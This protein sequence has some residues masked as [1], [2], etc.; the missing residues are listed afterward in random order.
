MNYKSTDNLKCD[1]LIIGAGVIGLTTAYE[2]KKTQ[3][4]CTIAI[5]EKEPDVARHASGRNS[6]VLHAGFYY[7]SDSLKA[8]FTKDGNRL[9]KEFC[10]ENEIYINECKKVVVATNEEELKSLYE[11]EKRG[12]QNNVDVR[13][14]D[15]E[16]LYQI[17]PNS[18][19]FKKALFSPTT[20]S[21]NPVE[22]CQKLKQILVQK[23]IEFF[24]NTIYLKNKGNLVS[25]NNQRFEAGFVINAA[26]L[27]ADLIARNFGFSKK[28]V[29]IPFK[30][31][32]LK[33][34]GKDCPVR[35][36]IYP[37]PN[38]KNPFLGVHYTVTS[39]N[40]I[41]IGPTATPAFWR[42]NY[43]G[44]RNFKLSEFLEIAY[45][46]SKLLVLN[47]FNFRELAISEIRKYNKKYFSSLALKLSSNCDPRNF[48]EWMMPGIRAQLL[49]K[50]TMQLEMDFIV[51]S[52]DHSLHIL[53]AVSPA[54]TC[55]FSFAKFL[56]NEK[57]PT[58][59]VLKS[60]IS[61]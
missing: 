12:K 54:F 24:F 20:A 59:S 1:F 13:L 9:M 25:T 43:S 11:L 55:S 6:G 5:I 35:T 52:N 32:Y 60:S 42:E 19:T 48:S 51:E 61:A 45:Y 49:N 17:E 47:S 26:G 28:Y 33:Y 8:K 21:V 38:L 4:E 22:V 57:I 2:L 40:S 37:V 7:T 39:N 36:N 30:G 41:K 53:N 56:V 14:I 16:E 15:E 23:G 29:I 3:P 27:Y 10:R 50:E 44:F 18:K 58:S 34:T 46:E 31:R